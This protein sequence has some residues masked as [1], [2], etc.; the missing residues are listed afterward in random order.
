MALCQH[1]ISYSPVFR[2]PRSE[3]DCMTRGSSPSTINLTSGRHSRWL[4]QYPACGGQGLRR[5]LPFLAAALSAM[6]PL[7]SSTW[8]RQD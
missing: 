8:I 5:M 2:Y 3:P 4:H 7:G 1:N 6:V